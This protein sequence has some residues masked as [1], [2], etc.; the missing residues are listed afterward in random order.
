MV[1]CNLF[2]SNVSRKENKNHLGGTWRVGV[3][4]VGVGVGVEVLLLLIVKSCCGLW[5]YLVVC[6]GLDKIV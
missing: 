1:K 6:E 4:C 5:C 2:Y 3:V